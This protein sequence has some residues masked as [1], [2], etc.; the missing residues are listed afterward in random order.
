MRIITFR[1]LNT[2]RFNLIAIPFLDLLWNKRKQKEQE[3]TNTL[4]GSENTDPLDVPSCPTPDFISQKEP[5]FF[6][7]TRFWKKKDQSSFYPLHLGIPIQELIHLSKCSSVDLNER[8][9]EPN[10]SY[11]VNAGTF[12]RRTCIF[13]ALRSNATNLEKGKAYFHALMLSKAMK[14]SKIAGI[15]LG[16]MK[17]WNDGNS[18]HSEQNV[19]MEMIEKDV[20]KNVD[21]AW[22]RFLESA[23][24]SGWNLDQ[25]DLKTKGFEFDVFEGNDHGD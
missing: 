25:I 11:I 17:R 15:R 21:F 10:F 14:E 8:L 4:P 20:H 6:F 19:L 12:R 2:V 22:E 24:L 3:L 23:K 16:L 9:R 5:L 18:S 7:S 13:V 1:S